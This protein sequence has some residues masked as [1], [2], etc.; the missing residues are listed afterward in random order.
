M[1]Y[2]L[3]TA[4]V[5]TIER[6]VAVYPVAGVTTNQ[7]ILSR[8]GAAPGALL[9]QIRAA[10]G[11]ERMLHAQV[12]A[13]ESG[14]MVREALAL[15]DAVGGNLYIK[16]PATPQGLEALP[17]LKKQG[18]R[19]TV[20]ALFSAAQALLFARA[21]ADFVAPF[22]SRLDNIGANGVG[23]VEEILTVFHRYGLATR[24]LA[25]SFRTPEQLRRLAQLGVDAATIAPPILEA[26]LWHPMTDDALKRF[27]AD[28]LKMTGGT[29]S[30]VEQLVRE[31]EGGEPCC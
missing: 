11:E 20:T 29:Q 2:L 15:C 7:S 22:V 6:L 18:L 8:E 26:L 3:D 21:G 30:W 5:E 1:L 4:N 9:R 10:I 24:V 12:T 13:H 31:R 23:V 14:Q 17:A 16:V 25:A 28:W 19:V 27:D